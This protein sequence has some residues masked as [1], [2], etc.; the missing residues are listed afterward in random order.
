MAATES[1]FS[2]IGY[3]CDSD[4]GHRVPPVVSCRAQGLTSQVVETVADVN[5]SLVIVSR[6]AS[7]LTVTQGAGDIGAELVI[8]L[9]AGIRLG[10]RSLIHLSTE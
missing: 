1:P 5:K 10:K 7:G 4:N 9:G 3:P 2:L 8:G 6:G